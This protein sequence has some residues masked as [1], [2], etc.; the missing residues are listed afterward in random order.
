M[1][2]LK[3]IGLGLLYFIEVVMPVLALLTTFISFIVNVIHAMWQT[4]P[5]T[6]VMS[7]V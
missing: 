3:K 6:P 2:M 5:S 4:P 7:C 1:K